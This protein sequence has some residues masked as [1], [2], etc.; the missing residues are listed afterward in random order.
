MEQILTK[1]LISTA[2]IAI[3][4]IFTWFLNER[5][6]RNDVEYRRK[7]ERYLKL[8]KGLEGFRVSLSTKDQEQSNKLIKDFLDQY[9]LCW[10][11][12]PDDVYYKIKKF[13]QMVSL[14]RDRDY[15]DIEKEN[16]IGEIMLAI[17]KDIYNKWLFKKGRFY[18]K[19][20]LKPEDYKPYE[21][22]I[23]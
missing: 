9:F 21:P 18:R 19:T 5:S 15:T 14:Q 17:R 4:G 6:K 23:K 22:I 16:A 7:E 11:Y 10:M 3:L 20:T 2:G 12:C 8:I 13:I 1:V